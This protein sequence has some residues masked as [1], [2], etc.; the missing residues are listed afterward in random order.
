MPST[1]PNRG[2]FATEGQ[3][4]GKP[5]LTLKWRADSEYPFSFGLTKAQLILACIDEIK[6]FVERHP[7]ESTGN[8]GRGRPAANR[9][10]PQREAARAQGEP[11]ACGFC[12]ACL[13]AAGK[14]GDPLHALGRPA[15]PSTNDKPPC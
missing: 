2:P 12:P 10:A 6:A 1:N 13:E 7:N 11:C 14:T 5:S 4:Q 3:Y 9:P 15:A 8:R